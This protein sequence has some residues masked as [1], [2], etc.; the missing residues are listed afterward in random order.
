MYDEARLTATATGWRSAGGT[1]EVI[2]ADGC[3]DVIVWEHQVLLAGPS[4]RWLTTRA[5]GESPTIGLRLSP[6]SARESL[7]LDLAEVRDRQVPLADAAGRAVA[8]RWGDALRAGT[9]AGLLGAVPGWIAVADRSARHGVPVGVLG[10]ELA[11]SERQLR[12]RMVEHFG[13]GYATLVRLRRAERAQRL[14]AGGHSPADVAARAGF[15]DQPHLT[16]E[17]RHF[18]GR[19]PGRLAAQPAESSEAPDGSAA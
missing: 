10:R 19:T 12:R 7:A 14:L 18:T 16:R 15:S 2:P 5:D 13:Y 3:V 6:G 17:L 9:A 11:W 8:G 1:A 4:T